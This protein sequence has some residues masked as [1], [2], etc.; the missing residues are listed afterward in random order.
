MQLVFGA[1]HC[2]YFEVDLCSNAVETPACFQRLQILGGTE[3]VRHDNR[4]CVPHFGG[5]SRNISASIQLPENVRCDRCT[6][7]WTYRT[8][9]ACFPNFQG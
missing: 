6:L 5:Q 3:R 1:M 9:Y 2:G 8:N 7:R 4:M